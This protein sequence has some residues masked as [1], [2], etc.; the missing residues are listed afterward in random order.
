M[1]EIIMVPSVPPPPP[2]VPGTK[3]EIPAYPAVNDSKHNLSNPET[4]LIGF[5]LGCLF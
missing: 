5:L 2:Q 3:Y 1:E 4:G